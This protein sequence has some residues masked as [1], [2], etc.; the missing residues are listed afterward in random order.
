MERRFSPPLF[1]FQFL[2]SLF[3]FPPTNGG[4]PFLVCMLISLLGERGY[5][6][7]DIDLFG[8]SILLFYSMSL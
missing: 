1:P 3:P 8:S 6:C 5:V 7:G 2:V 4:F